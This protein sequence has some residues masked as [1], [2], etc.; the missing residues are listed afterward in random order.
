MKRKRITAHRALTMLRDLERV[1][2]LVSHLDPC[3]Y[4]VD[5]TI[6]ALD[7]HVRASLG[8]GRRR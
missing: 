1:R 7:D 2:H 3:R 5:R 6:D 4:V 8:K